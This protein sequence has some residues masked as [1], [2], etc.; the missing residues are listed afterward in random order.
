MNKFVNRRERGVSQAAYAAL[1]LGVKPVSHPGQISAV[2]LRKYLADKPRGEKTRVR[3]K[4]EQ[5]GAGR[6][7]SSVFSMW[8]RRDSIPHRYLIPLADIIGVDPRVM[9][10]AHP[11]GGAAA[12][13]RQRSAKYRAAG[14]LTRDENE[15][16]YHYRRASPAW[17]AGLRKLA[18]LH[19]DH[20]KPDARE[21]M[22][23]VL[24][25]ITAEPVPDSRLG[26]EWKRP[27]RR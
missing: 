25:M 24:D 13:L 15:L 16:I 8:L 18:R 11:E 1:T 7:T 4:L 22:L 10:Y 2:H 27:D 19:P 26:K 12:A 21:S 3:A 20:Q 9:Q 14:E 5:R 23:A 17:Q 6:V